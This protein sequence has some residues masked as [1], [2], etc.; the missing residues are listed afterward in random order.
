MRRRHSCLCWLFGV[1]CKRYTCFVS[2]PTAA[3]NRNPTDPSRNEHQGWFWGSMLVGLRANPEAFLPCEELPPFLLKRLRCY[4]GF[5]AAAPGPGLMATYASA[6]KTCML[7]SGSKYLII[8]DLLTQ[9]LCYDVY[10]QCACDTAGQK[11]HPQVSSVG[12]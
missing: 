4:K 10:Y 11:V 2:Y 7:P 6:S 3:W 12:A 9:N 1:V 8:I 5:R